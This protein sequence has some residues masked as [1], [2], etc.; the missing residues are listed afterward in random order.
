MGFYYSFNWQLTGLRSI[1]DF[2][3]RL[4][5]SNFSRFIID[6]KR[7]IIEGILFIAKNPRIKKDNEKKFISGFSRSTN[8]CVKN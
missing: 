8:E 2:F 6:N 7:F 4:F 5:P 3:S 1:F